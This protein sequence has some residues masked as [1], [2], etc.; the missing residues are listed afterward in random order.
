MNVSVIAI[1]ILLPSAPVR[2]PIINVQL[3]ILRHISDKTVTQTALPFNQ[4]TTP[5]A[6]VILELPFT[7]LLGCKNTTVRTL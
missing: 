4:S 5:K 1:K 3:S 7:N 6:T 2:I